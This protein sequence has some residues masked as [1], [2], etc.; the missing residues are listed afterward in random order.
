MAANDTSAPSSE[1]ATFGKLTSGV[2]SRRLIITEF[3]DR[4]MW[5]QDLSA[6]L[7]GKSRRQLEHLGE[8]PGPLSSRQDVFDQELRS[9]AR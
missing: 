2:E 1:D 9:G 5:V 4:K 8:P 7:H 3:D 6:K